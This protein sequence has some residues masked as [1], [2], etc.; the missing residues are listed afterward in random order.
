MLRLQNAMHIM[1]CYDTL[2]FDTIEEMLTCGLTIKK[3]KMH[4]D[5]LA[6]RKSL[7]V[8]AT[9]TSNELEILSRLK[10]FWTY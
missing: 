2:D 5:A 7:E 10:N 3:F 9:R 4:H 1:K 6:E 8:A